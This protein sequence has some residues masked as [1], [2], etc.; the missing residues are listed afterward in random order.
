[1]RSWD[2]IV[3]KSHVVQGRKIYVLDL[4]MFAEEHG[5]APCDIDN[6]FRVDPITN[7]PY[8][9]ND[10]QASSAALLRLF[11]P[12]A[13]SHAAHRIVSVL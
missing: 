9:H 1:M 8:L 2:C 12:H 6:T 7:V 13:W 10:P 5:M 11:Q 4:S 3:Q